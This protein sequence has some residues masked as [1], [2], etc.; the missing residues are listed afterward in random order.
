MVV[1]GIVP[2]LLGVVVVSQILFIHI[3]PSPL[4]YDVVLKNLGLSF[5]F[6]LPVEVEE[7]HAGL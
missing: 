7:G 1:L 6:D 5:L 3:H 2:F 4:L